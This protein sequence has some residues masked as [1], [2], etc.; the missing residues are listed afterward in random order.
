MILLFICRGLVAGPTSI[1]LDVS[2]ISSFLSHPPPFPGRSDSVPRLQ[3]M[4]EADA[5]TS[6]MRGRLD[7]LIPSSDTKDFD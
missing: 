3:N 4:S 5:G 7:G 1:P 2:M 6:I